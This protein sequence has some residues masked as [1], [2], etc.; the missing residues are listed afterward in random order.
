ML[1]ILVWVT[2]SDVTADIPYVI[3]DVT[4]AIADVTYVIAD[5]PYVIASK[6]W[7]SYL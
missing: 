5:I 7:Q 2:R 3:A 6:A 4:Y 1:S